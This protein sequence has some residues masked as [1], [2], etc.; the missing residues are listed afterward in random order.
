MPTNAEAFFRSLASAADIEQLIST[1]EDLYF[2]AK[3]VNNETFK[4]DSDQGALAKAISA[5]ANSDGGVIVYGL[6]AKRD[7]QGRDVVQ[8]AKP[9]ADPALVQSKILGLVGQL[10]QPPVEG[11]LAESRIGASRQGYVLVLVPPSDSGPHRARPQGKYFRRHGSASLPMEHYE[12]EEMFGRRRRP[13]LQLYSHFV[14]RVGNVADGY[15]ALFA[16]GLRN[17]G[18][19]IA[20]CPGLLLRNARAFEGGFDAVGNVGL[21]ALP[22]SDHRNLFYGGSTD[23]VIYPGIELDVAAVTHRVEVS[24]LAL[25]EIKSVSCSD[26]SISYEIYAEDMPTIK[27][28]MIIHSQ[29]ILD[30]MAKVGM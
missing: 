7:D 2:D 15:F 8:A 1:T 22:T 9:L 29:E 11:I 23:R 21:P 16:I 27:S 4:A 13:L 18:R 26:L 10:L 19:G 30:A 3:T 17:T 28:T 6:E 20:K 24:R 25:G 5:F 12:L 14:R